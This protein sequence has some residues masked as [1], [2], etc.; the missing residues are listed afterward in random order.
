METTGI[1]IHIPFCRR[2]CFY[3]HFAKQAHDE[4]L[5][6]KYMAALVE[7][8]R[9]AGNNSL[10]IDTIYIGGGS[11]SLLTGSQTAALLAAINHNFKLADEVEITM[12]MNPEDVT[13]G[14]LN[15]LKHLGV[16]RLSIGVQSFNPEDLDYL[17]RSHDAEQSLAAME[18][19][20]ETGFTNL[21]VDFII[22]LP[23]HTRKHLESSFSILD[24]HPV[25]HV[26]A[27][28]LEGVE[29]GEDRQD[30]DVELYHFTREQLIGRGYEHYEISNFSK[31]GQSSSHNMKYWTGKPYIGLG[32]SAAGYPD[33]KDTKNTEDLEEY[34]SKIQD[35]QLPRGPVTA[36]DPAIR[37]IITGLR[38]PEGLPA[39]HFKHHQK[40]LDFLLENN[41]LVKS[42]GHIA[43]PPDKLLLLNE[44]LSYFL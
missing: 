3:C 35:N 23:H 29:E 6:Y 30:R 9:L 31:P 39:E 34:F 14:Q 22:S 44:I 21:N 16:N 4:S 18:V 8:I 2:T 41:F 25:P 11:P 5:V 17:R 26:S 24:S 42:N 13:A 32:L 33:G 12:E 43:V 7:E 10:P 37:D 15:F 28:I 40:P 20:L 1:Y 38:L 19:A 27:Y 36:P